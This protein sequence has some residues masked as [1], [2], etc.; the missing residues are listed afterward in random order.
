MSRPR[1]NTLLS[2]RRAALPALC[3]GVLFA[4][5]GASSAA[6][7][8]GAA[9]EAESVAT[10]WRELQ[11]RDRRI[12]FTPRTA[13][14]ARASLFE[15]ELT[16]EE[17]AIALMALGCARPE[18]L[19]ELPTLEANALEGAPQVRQ[20]AIL[21]L[22]EMGIGAEAV[23]ARLLEEDNAAL[24]G[25]AMQAL[26][27]LDRSSSL[28]T[29]SEVAEGGG[30][31]AG[32]ARDLLV[33]A[34]DPAVSKPT[35]V[36]ELRYELRWKAAQRYGLVDGVS[37]KL[38]NLQILLEEPAFLDGVILRA[39]AASAEP[40]VHDH[41]LG[42]LLEHESEASLRAAT[43]AM[44]EELAALIANNLYVPQG[45][46]AWRVILGEIDEAGNEGDALALLE[47]SLDEPKV[48]VESL[49]LL[50]RAGI[51]DVLIGLEDEWA[52]LA[53]LERLRALQAWG[54]T[55]DQELLIVLS[56]FQ[57]ESDP[58]VRAGLLIARA[59]LGDLDARESLKAILQDHEHPD[60]R[61][62]MN[63]ALRVTDA[64]VVRQELG[65]TLGALTGNDRIRVATELALRGDFAARDTLA[66]ELR[67]GL[68]GG[69]LGARAIRA[70]AGSGAGLHLELFV[71][72]FP[73]E[74]DLD[75]NI[76]LAIALLDAKAQRSLLYLRPALWSDPFD[77]SVLAGLLMIQVTGMHGLRDEFNRPPVE[78]NS[79]DFRRLGF[80]L[81]EWGG[82]SEIE[83]MIQ[84]Q[85]FM[86]GQPVLQGA[87]LGALGKRTH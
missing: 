7:Q 9:Q 64:K 35:W 29:I 32:L 42:M 54:L 37:W 28:R 40:G 45:A 21:A 47:L 38:R 31:H 58:R 71:K 63:V 87:V 56:N 62:T 14:D 75:V 13:H 76:E 73:V 27:C 50:A 16:K 11:E 48:L 18:A 57:K 82:L 3:L 60:F 49:L 85:G 43:R 52:N 59:R 1:T 53:P 80:A 68:P 81:G 19:R 8:E 10:R 4:I 5:G 2:P 72:H 46:R 12:S 69:R 23:L 39:A 55:E 36:G 78:A 79:R 17:R 83:W 61:V 84:R 74:G 44:P 34:I 51:S 30:A 67:M 70:L 24:C 22:G 20:A 25:C 15:P 86:P 33:G 26:L 6:L 77:R 66:E 41:L 65:H